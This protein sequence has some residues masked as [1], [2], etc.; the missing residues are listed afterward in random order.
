MTIPNVFNSDDSGTLTLQ[1]PWSK[2]ELIEVHEVD[3]TVELI[4]KETS[5][6]QPTSYPPQ[7]PEVRVFKVVYSCKKGKWHKSEPIYGEVIPAQ[8][9][10]YEF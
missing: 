3:E 5:M 4:F 6:V 1:T 8:P 7:P 2:P 9:E 10:S